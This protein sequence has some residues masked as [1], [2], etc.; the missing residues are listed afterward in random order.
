MIENENGIII[1]CLYID[2]TLCIGNT[3]ARKNIKKEIKN[4]LSPKKTDL[5]RNMWDA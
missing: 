1:I 4:N 3:E 5:L 2:D